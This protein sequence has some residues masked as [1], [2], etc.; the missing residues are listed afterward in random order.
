MDDRRRILEL[1][2]S[3]EI[4]VEEGVRRLEALAASEAVEALVEPAAVAEEPG[5]P[6]PRPALVRIIWQAVFWSGVALVI[7]GGLLVAAVYAWS[8]AS[9]WL[10]CGWP[11]FGVG[12]LV[13]ATGWWMRTAR[14]LSLRVKN[15][16]HNIFFALPLPLAPLAWLMRIL[17]PFVPELK[18]TGID[19]LLMAMQDELKDGQPLIV[20]VN[21]GEDGEH[22]QIYFG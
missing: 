6:I 19:E 21:E 14:W 4:D 5:P 12:V 2:E 9:G 17:Q 7:G 11:L 16:E 8:V 15:E 1:I 3:G 20:D 10:I 18:D 22:V 13:L